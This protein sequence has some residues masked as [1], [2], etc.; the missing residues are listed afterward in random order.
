MD[1]FLAVGNEGP[2]AVET[3]VVVTNRFFGGAPIFGAYFGGVLQH[4]VDEKLTTIEDITVGPRSVAAFKILGVL[5]GEG[6]YRVESSFQGDG[7]RMGAKLRIKGD[8]P[9]KLTLSSFA[10]IYEIESVKVNGETVKP[11]SLQLPAGEAAVEVG[12]KNRVLDFTRQDWGAVELF[13]D[14]RTNVCLIAKTASPFN[15]GTANLLN[16]FIAQYDAE[17]GEL[18]NLKK[19]EVLDEPPAGFDGWKV[20]IRPDADVSPSRVRIDRAAKEI[21]VEGKSSGE[22]RRAMVVLL[23][24]LDRKYPHI[25]RFYS[26]KYFGGDHAKMIEK[27]LKNKET[28][29]FFL[30]LADKRFLIKPILRPEHERLYEND[31]IDF[32]GKYDLRRPP[33][34]F[35]PTYGED[36]V[37]GYAGE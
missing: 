8:K 2:K 26:L 22:A 18:G 12:Y 17:D 11:I 29:Q 28:Q 37:Y 31:T 35:E 3:D 13:K 7:L 10:P 33:Y 25:G 32:T 14:G 27:R 4:L 15:S 30:N 19:A 23:R 20:F 21:H 36:Y 34:L 16:E 24:L 9:S 1:S 6:T 5:S